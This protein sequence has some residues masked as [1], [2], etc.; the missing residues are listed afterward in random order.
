ELATGKLVRDIKAAAAWFLPN[1]GLLTA[2][3]E[4]G[5]ALRDSG[6]TITDRATAPNDA[7]ILAYF[8]D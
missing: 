6:G 4:G 8:P 1:G 2:D 7:E 3:G 5:L